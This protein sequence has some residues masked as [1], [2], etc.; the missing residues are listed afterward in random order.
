MVSAKTLVYS[1]ISVSFGLLVLILLFATAPL[2]RVIHT[3]GAESPSQSGI[4]AEIFEPFIQ[5]G[6]RP[7]TGNSGP[8]KKLLYPLIKRCSVTSTLQTLDDISPGTAFGSVWVLAAAE[9][10]T[11]LRLDS[12]SVE[13]L[14]NTGPGINGQLRW[15][16]YPYSGPI[17]RF[18]LHAESGKPVVLVRTWTLD[19]SGPFAARTRDRV[20][21]ISRRPERMATLG[22]VGDIVIEHF[23]KYSIAT[24]GRNYTFQNVNHLLDFPEI[25]SGNLEFVVSNRK[26]REEK[27]YTFKASEEQ[28]KLIT[29]S[30]FDYFTTANNHAMDY[31][32]GSLLDTIHVLNKNGLSYS[33]SGRSIEDA[34]APAAMPGGENVLDYF[35][36]CHVTNEM[37]GYKTMEEL[38]A[39]QGVPGVAWWDKPR[40]KSLLEVSRGSGN[41]PIV[42]FHTGLEYESVPAN[43]IR[44]RMRWLVDHG[45]EAVICHHSHVV[46]GVEIYKGRVIAY[47]LG[48]FLFDIQK[49]FADEGI[50]LYLYLEQGAVTGWAAYPTVCHHGAVTQTPE[51][52]SDIE[53]R[54]IKMSMDL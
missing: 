43:W 18:V 12:A 11:P 14:C 15:L 1:A 35:S 16:D 49:P 46:S 52:L 6:Y 41:L 28:F 48:D 9:D 42:Q 13:Q 22:F 51:R 50:I 8:L 25:M 23:V 39:S 47:S 54:F 26:K 3:V 31:G 44:R 5:S 33:G 30:S 19:I 38:S 24:K 17:E 36:L 53:S 7:F 20:L 40:I 37:S 45:A 2:V 4:D 21:A 27:G 29:E 10:N 34:F 32:R